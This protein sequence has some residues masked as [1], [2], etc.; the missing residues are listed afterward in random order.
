MDEE[1]VFQIGKVP[2]T[3]PFKRPEIVISSPHIQRFIEQLKSSRD[4]DYQYKLVASFSQKN[5]P[6]LERTR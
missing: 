5:L 2:V 3:E 6:G 1:K 4:L